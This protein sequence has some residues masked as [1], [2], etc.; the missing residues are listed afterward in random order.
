MIPQPTAERKTAFSPDFSRDG[1]YLAYYATPANEWTRSKGWRNDP[2]KIVIRPLE[3][4]QERELT[5]SPK[6]SHKYGAPRLR[7]APDG[8]SIVIQGRIETG[9]G[10]IF[11]GDIETGKLTAV[12]TAGPQP[13]EP[14]WQEYRYN[15]RGARDYATFP[16]WS[17]D[18]K[19]VFFIRGHL[20]ENAPR[21]RQCG[22]SRGKGQ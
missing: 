7:W 3:T 10:G 13:T 17:A 9:Q 11:R 15:Y 1:K 14:G 5:L 18:G 16:E 8:R 20:D 12:V 21:N 2:G 4:G 22:R 6:F 19:T